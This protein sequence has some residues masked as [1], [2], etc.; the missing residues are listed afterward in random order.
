MKNFKMVA[1][2]G[3]KTIFLAILNLHVTPML[4]IKFSLNQ[5]YG[6]GGD[7]ILRISRQNEKFFEFYLMLLSKFQSNQTYGSG[8]DDI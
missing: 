5:I 8:G 3:I 7:V 4:P 1:I 6:W 2:L